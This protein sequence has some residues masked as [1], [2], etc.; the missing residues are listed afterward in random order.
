M[1]R[2]TESNLQ[3]IR[4]AFKT[5][6]DSWRRGRIREYIDQQTEMIKPVDLEERDSVGSPLASMRSLPRKAVDIAQFYESPLEPELF[7][8]P[9]PNSPE[10]HESNK[11]NVQPI[12]DLQFA[13]RQESKQRKTKKLEK[14]S[15][16]TKSG[17]KKSLDAKNLLSLDVGKNLGSSSAPPAPTKRMTVCTTILANFRF[18]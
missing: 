16:K 17:S 10:S 18:L 4:E 2:L 15:R 3:K 5:S 8:L 6:P 7:N 1:S 9:P 11:E 14:K 13:K 12:M